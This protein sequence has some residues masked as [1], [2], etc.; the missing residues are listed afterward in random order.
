[1]LFLLSTMLM[2]KT[3]WRVA[4]YLFTIC[5]GCSAA[6]IFS[7]CYVV[8]L[9]VLTIQMFVFNYYEVLLMRFYFCEASLYIYSIVFC[10]CAVSNTIDSVVLIYPGNRPWSP[11]T[12]YSALSLDSMQGSWAVVTFG[13]RALVNRFYPMLAD[14]TTYERRNCILMDDYYI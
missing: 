6:C 2:S 3:S 10:P 11:G 12:L 5:T 4:Y 13:I 8:R 1:M 7:E 9:D 14:V